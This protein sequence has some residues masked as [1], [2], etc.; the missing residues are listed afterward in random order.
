MFS[1]LEG[2]PTNWFDWLPL[3]DEL[4]NKFANP[5]QAIVDTFLIAQSQLGDGFLKN[6]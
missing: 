5:P 4:R 2:K 6:T 3:V 1:I